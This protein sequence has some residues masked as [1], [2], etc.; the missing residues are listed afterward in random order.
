[1]QF[2]F[3]IFRRVEFV[4]VL[5]K[6]PCEPP[7]KRRNNAASA[8]ESG[9]DNVDVSTAKGFSKSRHL[10]FLGA[11]EFVLAWATAKHLPV[12]PG[13]AKQDNKKK[14]RN[15]GGSAL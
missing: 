13:R 7:A 9:D 4:R 11:K 1:M 15:L 3:A 10:Y 8:E 12:C 5:V 6:K 14:R 2:F